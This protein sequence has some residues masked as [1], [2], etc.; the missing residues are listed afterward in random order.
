MNLYCGTHALMSEMGIDE[1][2]EFQCQ[3]L[4]RMRASH[5]DV[6]E[7]LEAGKIGDEII[8]VIEDTAAAV[9]KSLV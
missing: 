7:Q 6:L 8:K 3:F 1:V 4:D 2:E 5:Q 9:A